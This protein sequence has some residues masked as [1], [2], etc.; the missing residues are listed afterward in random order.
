[1]T[2]RIRSIKPEILEDEKTAGLPH[3]A[4]RVFVSL[5]LVVDDYGNCRANPVFLEGQTLWGMP[6]DDFGAN[7]ARLSRESLITLYAVRGQAY[8]HITNWEKHQ[9]V[10]H[11]GKPRVPGPEEGEIVLFI[12]SSREP[13]ENLATLSRLIPTSD[14]DQDP[15][16][17][18]ELGPTRDA[19]AAPHEPAQAS[20]PVEPV[21]TPEPEPS[22]TPKPSRRKPK[23]P[24]PEDWTP[25]ARHFQ[26]A[27]ERSVDCALAAQKFRAHAESVDRR[28]ADWDRAFDNWLLSERPTLRNQQTFDPMDRV[29]Q[30]RAEGR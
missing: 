7:L 11:P 6:S 17:D 24:I 23:R 4:W 5:F 1:V 3:E 19:S 18:Q 12:N 13:R 9:K 27:T 14:Q 21:A 22:A 20:A 15:E 28:C 25:K 29:R 10:D 26:Q 2:G 8:L 16:E 30:L